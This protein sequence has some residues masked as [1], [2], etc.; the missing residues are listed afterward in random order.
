[1]VLPAPNPCSNLENKNKESECEKMLMRQPM[2]NIAMPINSIF[3]CHAD[4]KVGHKLIVMRHSQREI[5]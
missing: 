2:Q 3:F 1:M 4:R 5:M